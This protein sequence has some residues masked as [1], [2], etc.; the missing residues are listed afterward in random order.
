MDQPPNYIRELK[1]KMHIFVKTVYKATKQFPKDELFG[2]TSQLRRAV[3]SIILNFIE[4]YARKRVAVKK[5]FWETSYGSLKETNYLVYF[6]HTEN[7]IPVEEYNQ[8][9]KQGDEIGAMIW[10]ALSSLESNAE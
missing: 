5:N 9:K 3:L 6:A 10:H 7:W 2:A 1:K 8:I 4:G